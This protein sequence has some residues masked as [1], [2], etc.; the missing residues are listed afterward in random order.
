MEAILLCLLANQIH[1]LSRTQRRFILL[2]ILLLHV[3][4]FMFRPVLGPSSGM[5]IQISYKGKHEDMIKSTD[6]LVYIRY[7]L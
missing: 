7:F 6:R 3:V 1:L 2:Q 4:C 5:S